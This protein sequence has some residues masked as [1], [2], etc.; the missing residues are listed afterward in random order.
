[1]GVVRFL[2]FILIDGNWRLGGVM[3]VKIFGI[4]CN[5]KDIEYGINFFVEDGIS[6]GLN[7]IFVGFNIGILVVKG[8]L[9]DLF[10]IFFIGDWVLD[11][12]WFVVWKFCK[13]VILWDDLL[14]LKLWELLFEKFVLFVGK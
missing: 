3:M 10:N 9:D 1:M 11:I 8:W 13:L 5:K 14:M 6:Y 4:R 12:F 7:V 2:L